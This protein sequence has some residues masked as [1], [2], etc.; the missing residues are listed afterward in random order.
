MSLDIFKLESVWSEIMEVMCLTAEDCSQRSAEPET[1]VC[2]VSV[3][4]IT[5]LIMPW[6]RAT[7][8]LY[9]CEEV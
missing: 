3:N 1:S 8:K 6:T 7:T 9:P 5:N 2:P 4:D